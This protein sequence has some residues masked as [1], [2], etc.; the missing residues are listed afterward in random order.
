[1]T[2]DF[3]N[4]KLKIFIKAV[5]VALILNTVF[6]FSVGA[7]IYGVALKR[8]GE[9]HVVVCGDEN[10]LEREGTDMYAVSVDGV[11]LHGYYVENPDSGNRLAVLCHGYSG[12]GRDMSGFAHHFYKLGYSVFAPDAR[13]HGTS[14]GELIG[15]GYIE[16]QDIILWINMLTENKP[17]AQVILYG[18]SMGGGTVLFTSGESN[19]PSSVRA[20]ISDCAYTD[21]Y[22]EIGSAIRSSLPWVPS[23]PVVD[24]ASVICQLDGGYSLRE[25]SC[26]E[27]V[28]RS[29]TP[30][31]FIH[32]SAD[33]YVPFDMLEPLY[34]SCAAPKQKLVVEGAAHAAS[35]GTDSEL[36]WNTVDSF[37]EGYI[38]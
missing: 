33:N 12:A 11:N 30:T 20:V 9:S 7:L 10:W 24:C 5:C 15:M 35:A 23:F 8:D 28:K 22:N 6:V 34:E 25:A 16:K 18:I 37:L 17:D 29:V 2:G 36:Y 1:M 32:G 21:I 4:K 19:L 13:C 14:G 38:K 26:I 31:L 3:V 27:A